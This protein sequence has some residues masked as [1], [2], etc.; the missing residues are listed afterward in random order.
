M[1]MFYSLKKKNKT[2]KKKKTNKTLK[3]R[4]ALQGICLKIGIKTARV[5]LHQ[6]A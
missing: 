4:M 6:L 5:Q 2:S 1:G 3:E